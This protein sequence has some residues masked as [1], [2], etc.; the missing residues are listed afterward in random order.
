MMGR[1]AICQSRSK[2]FFPIVNNSALNQRSFN[3]ALPYL[4]FAVICILGL[5]LILLIVPETK[6]KKLE[7]LEALWTKKS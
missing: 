6:N 4:G 7:E 2:W 1:A 5:I 3:G